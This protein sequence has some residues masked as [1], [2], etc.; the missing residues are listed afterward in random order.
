MQPELIAQI[1]AARAVGTPLVGVGTPDPAETIRLLAPELNGPKMIWDVVQGLSGL[2]DAG[3]RAVAAMVGDRDPVSA[4]ANPVDMLDLAMRTAPEDAVI[5]MQNG[6]RLLRGGQDAVTLAQAVWNCRDPFK[7]T[8]RLLL[9]F[10]ITAEGALPPELQ[11]DVLLFEEELPTDDALGTLLT[12]VHKTVNLPEPSADGRRKAVEALRGLSAFSAEQVS[13]MNLYQDG[14][15]LPGMWERKRVLIESTMGISVF[16]SGESFDNV[17]GLSQIKSFFTR[18]FEGPQPPSCLVFLDEIEKSLAGASGAQSDTSGTS[19]DQLG[20]IL[21]AMEDY[22]WTGLIGVGPPGV[23]KSFIAKTLGSQFNVP[24][25]SLDLGALKGSFV[26]QSEAQMRAAIKTIRG[27][28]GAGAY[29]FATCNKLDALPPELRRRFTDGLWFFDSP[30][31][32]EREPMWQLYLNQYKLS[33]KLDAR[34]KEV[35]A[36]PL[37]GAEIR[38]LA[39]NAYRLGVSP[40]EARDYI[41][42]VAVSDPKAILALRKKAHGR[43]LSA[44]YPGVYQMDRVDEGASTERKIAAPKLKPRSSL[45][46]D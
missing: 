1:V 46:R 13:A 45:L 34:F 16:R 43:F 39:F 29:Y 19:Q 24:V 42:P 17:K 25:L 7:T 10:G 44:N 37:T 23:G 41:V 30:S 6:L 31:A 28:A 40:G 36:E 20:S 3:K 21:R 18:L 32:E 8:G 2:D 14:L 15:D 11:Q 38:N 26:G 12:R 5:F 4:T 33:P 9:L 22:R 35:K 27:I